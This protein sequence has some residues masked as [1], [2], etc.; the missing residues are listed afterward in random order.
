M[1]FF[2]GVHRPN[3]IG[4]AP[5]PLLVSHATLHKIVRQFPRATLP[6]TLD[7]GGFHEVTKHGRYRWSPAEYAARVQLYQREI[8]QLKFAATQDY[9]CEEVALKKT[10]LTVAQHQA[11]TIDSF[12]ELSLR[13]PGVPWL[14]VLQGWCQGEYEDHFVAYARRGIDLRKEPRVGIG[15]ICRRQAMLRTSLMLSSFHRE[16]LALHAFGLKAN[17][18]NLIGGGALASADSAA[19]S[20]QARREHRNV[21]QW[22]PPEQRTKTGEQNKLHRALSWREQVIMP[23]LRGFEQKEAA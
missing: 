11:R 4:V 18:L 14:P 3:W 7:S 9:M 8:G 19:W 16:G 13:A 12:V 1:E 23:R 6:W 10:G 21:Q 5:V 22:L 2:L 15:S 20:Y 17:G